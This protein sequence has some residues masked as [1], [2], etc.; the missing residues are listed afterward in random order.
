MRF[1]LSDRLSRQNGHHATVLGHHV[2]FDRQN[3][4]HR[5]PDQ[6][7]LH[8]SG[9]G[10]AWL[11]CKGMPPKQNGA[12]FANPRRAINSRWLLTLQAKSQCRGSCR[13]R[14]PIKA[15]VGPLS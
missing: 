5:V 2:G 7:L 4:L 8:Q 11:D 9:H 13:R 1:A 12:A 3:F 14:L 6:I 15:A 10:D